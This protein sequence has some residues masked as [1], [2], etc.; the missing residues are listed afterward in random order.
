MRLGMVHGSVGANFSVDM[1]LVLE[2]ER[3]GYHSVWTSESYGSDAITPAAW[4]LART[5]RINVGTGIIQMAT[6]T[7][8]MAA[9]TAMT[10]QGMSGGRFI[11]GIGA[12]GP[13][14]IEGLHGVAYG[15]PI[16]RTRE[17]VSIVRKALAREE[18]IT[19]EGYH[20]Q[21]PYTGEGATGLGKPLKT[22]LHGDPSLKIYTAA[23][24]PAGVRLA[25]EIADGFLPIYMNPE[26]YDVFE[27]AIEEGFAKAGG[28]K[29]LADFD[30]APYV[31]IVMGDDLDA[32]RAPIKAQLALYVGGMGARDKNFYNDLAKRMGYEDAAVRIQDLFL[33][34]KK[35]EAAAAVPDSLVDEVALIG[36]RERIRDRLAVWQDAAKKGRVTTMLLR[37]PTP[38]A[39]RAVAEDV[40]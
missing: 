1:D 39:L 17:Y 28:G 11:L 40:L 22:I 35:D 38:D 29:G 21:L 30:I 23:I 19:H 24:T 7:P 25:A 20:Y 32:C 15:R 13:Q 5:T 8:A 26:R 34:G 16:T 4:I 6:R 10:L 31:N 2:A 14:V 36:P 27:S 3:L 18:P 33:D 9:M 12:S 37:R